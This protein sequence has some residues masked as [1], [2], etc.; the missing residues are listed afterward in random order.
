MNS[1]ELIK[2]ICKERKIPISRL[3][4][5]L[6]YG[7]GYISQ[8]K[9][10]TVPSNRAVEIANYL[11]ITV[12][13]LMTGNENKKTP[14]QLELTC[15]GSEALT[16]ILADIYGRCELVDISGDYCDCIYFSIGK[17]KNRYALYETDFDNLYSS[18]KQIILQMTDLIKKDEIIVRRACEKDS[19]MPPSAEVY[20]ELRKNGTILPELELKYGYAQ[21]DNEH[22]Y[23]IPVA[24]RDRAD[25]PKESRTK[26]LMKQEDDIMNDRNF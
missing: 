15:S 19:N 16:S 24:A 22:D 7:N 2:K 5:D 10:G 21:D 11:D 3:E 4:R 1:V 6:R 18:I 8:L 20:A 25:I 23:L 17:G 26:D 12:D 9:K 13:Y 14:E